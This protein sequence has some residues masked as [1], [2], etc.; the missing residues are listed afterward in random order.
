MGDQDLARGEGE[1]ETRDQNRREHHHGPLPL[2]KDGN[3]ASD[4]RRVA[5]NARKEHGNG[6]QEVVGK[7]LS[8]A[9]ARGDHNLG[10]Q[11]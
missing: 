6:D 1:D 2:T 8:S 11:E 7:R 3:Q 4:T 10:D 5:S 9:L